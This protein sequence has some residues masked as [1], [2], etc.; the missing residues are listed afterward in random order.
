ME[1]LLEEGLPDGT[2]LRKLKTSKKNNKDPYL[3]S[4]SI[5]RSNTNRQGSI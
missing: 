1:D 3:K 5:R 2:K 4:M